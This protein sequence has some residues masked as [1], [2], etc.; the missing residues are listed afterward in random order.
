MSNSSQ[1][2]IIIDNVTAAG[3]TYSYNETITVESEDPKVITAYFAEKV[4]KKETLD[5]SYQ[6]TFTEDKSTDSVT[7]RAAVA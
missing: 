4:I 3:R 1:L 2:D 6:F 5:G 7:K